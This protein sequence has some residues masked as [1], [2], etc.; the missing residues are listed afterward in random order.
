M[1]TSDYARTIHP[2]S[3]GW[4]PDDQTRWGP[5]I[6]AAEHHRLSGRV[7]AAADFIGQQLRNTM[8]R[9]WA[10]ARAGWPFA[11]AVG[12]ELEARIARVL[13]A[14]QVTEEEQAGS[15]EK[16]YKRT[17]GIGVA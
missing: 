13:S 17:H 12:E 9:G 1:V 7:Q 2:W 3:G 6:V 10:I 4:R 8:P 15:F 5:G 14:G 16:A 11:L